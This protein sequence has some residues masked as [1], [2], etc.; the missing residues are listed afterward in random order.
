M[1]FLRKLFRHVLFAMEVDSS[2]FATEFP[3]HGICYEI[4]V[5]EFVCSELTTK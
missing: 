4:F 5:T 2:E 3:R 1:E